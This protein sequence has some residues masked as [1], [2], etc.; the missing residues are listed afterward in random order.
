MTTA[1]TW[2]NWSGRQTSSPTALFSPTS[3]E[4][5]VSAVASAAADG[6]SVRAVGASH[7]HSRIAAP[8]GVLLNLDGWQGV[9]S[10]DVDAQQAIVRS[11]SRIF[12]LGAPLHAHGLALRNQGDIDKQSIAGATSTGTHGT[13]PTNQ[14]LSASVEGVRLVLASGEVVSCSPDER[15]ELFELARH[16]LGG[17]GVITEFTLGLRPAYRLHE[18]L[19]KES[20]DDVFAR[21]D[22]LVAGTRHFEFFW[23]PQL[24]AC[25]CKTL[26]ETDA[27]VDDLP[28]NKLERI[29]WS[30]NIISSIRDDKHTEMEYSVPA[31]Q[32]PACFNEVREMIL[33]DFPD[34]AWPLEYR[35]VR[36]DDIW[37][38]AAGGRETV[39]ISAHQDISLDD[40][41]LFEACEEIFRRYD[42]RP[43]W[44][45]VH[46]LS[47]ADLADLYP[48]YRD[49]WRIRDEHDPDGLFV[50]EDLAR[51][52]P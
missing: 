50:T 9:V 26:A 40:R 6:A 44:G 16:S 3:E 4:E 47:G 51:L 14:N 27:E 31:D 10:A 24:D 29:G 25:A 20:P 18:R 42:G 37:I 41:D 7:S 52:R 49:W 15:P 34:L 22:E 2:S 21:I 28:D 23:M 45:K 13:G 36:S 19:W 38:S 12:E 48:R 32:G 8:D 43:H 39:T 17:V 11:G 33:R 30:H 5:I 46:Y 35:T 1:A